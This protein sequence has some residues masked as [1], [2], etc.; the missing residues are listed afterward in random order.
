MMMVPIR[1]QMPPKKKFHLE[2]W[3]GRRYSGENI[4]GVRFRET[5]AAK[6]P[7]RSRVPGRHAEKH[8]FTLDHAVVCIGEHRNIALSRVSPECRAK[9]QLRT[10]QQRE[11][12]RERRQDAVRDARRY[13]ADDE[14]HRQHRQ[15]QE[16]H[17]QAIA[18][19]APAK[20]R[21]LRVQ[22]KWPSAARCARHR[23]HSED[24]VLWKRE[25]GTVREWQT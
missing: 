19:V 7:Q 10:A 21:R 22:D 14:R 18:A 6:Q 12:Q 3:I 15:A 9:P 25:T 13:G 4:Q 24:H 2:A 16:P 17:V 20:C 1:I 11:R 23:A 5:R 8:G